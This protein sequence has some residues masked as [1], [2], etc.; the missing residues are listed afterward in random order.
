MA[1]NA[2]I[3]ASLQMSPMSLDDCSEGFRAQTWFSMQ[4]IHLM[5][6]GRCEMVQSGGSPRCSVK[7]VGKCVRRLYNKLMLL[8]ITQ[9]EQDICKYAFLELNKLACTMLNSTALFWYHTFVFSDS[10]KK[11]IVY[12]NI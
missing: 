9:T 6:R 1:L 5:I 3:S 12:F 7:E 2:S 11:M 4:A 8:G 10:E